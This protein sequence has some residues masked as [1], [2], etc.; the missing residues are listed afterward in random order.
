MSATLLPNPFRYNQD[1]AAPDLVPDPSPEDSHPAPTALEE[2]RESA[3]EQITAAWQLHVERIQD[4]LHAGW[5]ESVDRVLDEHFDEL[6]YAICEKAEHL[7]AS[8]LEV[9]RREIT[10]AIS[11]AVRRLRQF[12]S[13]A[14]WCMALLDA[15]IGFSNRVALFYAGSQGFRFLADRGPEAIGSRPDEEIPLAHA[16][17]L[18]GA[19][20]S[21]DTVVTMRIGTELS[22]SVAGYFGEDANQRVYLFPVATSQR[23]VAV[24]YAEPGDRGVDTGALELL[25]TVAGAMLESHLAAS[26]SRRPSNVVAISSA[27]PVAAIAAPAAETRAGAPSWS[28]LSHD[29]QDLHLK[30][31]RFARVKVAEMR[32]YKS[33]AVR[34]GRIEQNLYDALRVE[35]DNGREAYKEQ[36]LALSPTML[37]YFHVELVRTLANDDDALLGADYPGPLV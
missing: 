36:F 1:V 26:E 15:G 7:A 12:E 6:Q 18:L 25:A 14:Q 29:E 8:Q 34:S 13:E 5:R 35:I 9:A 24:L 2:A 16:P 27:P 19:V 10:G 11:L 3:R 23:I 20:E 28:S 32:L 37:D 33:A 22:E 4:V 30:A 21:T 17:A 31:Q